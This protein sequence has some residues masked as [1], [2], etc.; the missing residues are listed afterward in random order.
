MDGRGVSLLPNHATVLVGGWGC[1]ARRGPAARTRYRSRRRQLRGLS[2]G[3][4]R[5]AVE[6][7]VGKGLPDQ[8]AAAQLVRIKYVGNRGTISSLDGGLAIDTLVTTL[9]APIRSILVQIPL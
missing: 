7:P 8:S 1:V 4:E 5:V 2:D 3:L 9:A 6:Q